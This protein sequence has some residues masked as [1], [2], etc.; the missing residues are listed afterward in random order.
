MKMG[1]CFLVVLSHAYYYVHVYSFP[2]KCRGGWSS[3]VKLQILGKKTSQVHL[4]IKD[5][6]NTT[7]P[8]LTNLD[9]FPLDACCSTLPLYS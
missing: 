5:D 6:L 1:H 3:R 8:I 2:L 9:N 4:I 7:S